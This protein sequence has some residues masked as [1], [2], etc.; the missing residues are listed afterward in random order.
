[1]SEIHARALPQSHLV[2]PVKESRDSFSAIHCRGNVMLLRLKTSPPPGEALG[3]RPRLNHRS[4]W[5][6]GV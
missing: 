2:V 4:G 3:L 5:M 1:M 6:S